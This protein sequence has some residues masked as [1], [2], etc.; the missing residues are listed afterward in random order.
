MTTMDM[1]HPLSCVWK[2]YAHLPQNTD[3]T[4]ES[5]QEVATL[6]TIEQTID[7]MNAIP[8][9]MVENAMWFLMRESILP[10]YEDSRNKR[11]GYF[12]YKIVNKLVATTWKTLVY[13][14]IA[15]NASY[16]ELFMSKVCGITISP[17]R[18]FCIIKVW[19]T[20]CTHQDSTVIHEMDGIT[21]RGC[22][23]SQHPQVK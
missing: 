23:F 15:E 5:Y 9:P 4:L 10:M 17:K 11:G 13:E 1:H 8:N 21:P 14:I 7:T 12:S 20:D 22:L 3:W 18:G 16:N 2:L 6:S 19:M